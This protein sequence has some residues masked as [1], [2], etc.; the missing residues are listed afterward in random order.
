MG[1]LEK[2]FT[3]VAIFGQLHTV[4]SRYN[5]LQ[6]HPTTIFEK[7]TEDDLRSRIFETFVANF[8]LASPRVFLKHGIMAIINRFLP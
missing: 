5:E 2:N 3:C 4:E 1:G 8:L 6:G 7:Y